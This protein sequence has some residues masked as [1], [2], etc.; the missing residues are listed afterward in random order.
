MSTAA[1]AV[2]A[3][4][5][6][7]FG[8]REKGAGGNASKLRKIYVMV[9]CAMRTKMPTGQYFHGAHGASYFDKTLNLL[10]LPQAP[11]IVFRHLFLIK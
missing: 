5:L 9:G 1:T 6:I 3:V 2:T 4:A 7:L 8:K 11:L 10:A